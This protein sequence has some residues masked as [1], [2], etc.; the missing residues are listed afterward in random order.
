M[1][2]K[3]NVT[4]TEANKM[5]SYRKSSPSIKFLLKLHWHLWYFC[6][7]LH[8][9]L[10]SLFVSM[11][12]KHTDFSWL[13]FEF[14][15]SLPRVLYVL[16]F[17]CQIIFLWFHRS[18]TMN[19]ILRL[20]RCHNSPNSLWNIMQVYPLTMGCECNVY[21]Y[22]FSSRTTLWLFLVFCYSISGWRQIHFFFIWKSLISIH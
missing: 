5:L 8:R 4:E 11:H 6:T 3:R 17:F 10:Q 16:P 20:R 12:H 15:A 13:F 9:I 2:V 1:H 21:L 22:L 18:K 14:Y 7:L 19:F